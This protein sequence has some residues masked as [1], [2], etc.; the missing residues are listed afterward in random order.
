MP[1]RTD[2][3]KIMIIGSG[4]IIIGQAC[5]F[6][7]SGTQ[8]C[9][10]LRAEGY[11]VVLVNS[12]PATIMTDPEI[13]DRTYVEPL[14]LD[15]LSAVVERERPDAL[16][17]TMG[18]QTG[19]NLA[20]GLSERGVLDTFGVELIGANAQAIATA[21]DRDQFKSAMEEIGLEVPASGFASHLD[22][23]MAL[24]ERIGFPLMIRPSFILG[25]AGTGTAQDRA[26]LAKAAA[27]GL[28]ASPVHQIL[29][30]RSIAGWK[31]YELEV[32]R[33]RADNCVVVCSIENFDPMGVHT[34]D[35]ITVAP[36]QT[37]TDVEYQG[38][39][40]DAFACLRRVGVE[41]GGSNV[42]FAVD[43]QTGRRVI[44]EMNPRVSRSSALAS[45][46]T[47]FPI[48]KIAA[49]LAVGYHLDEIPNDITG[50]T[51]ASFE[52]TI[53]YVVVKIPRFQFEKFPG[54]DNKLGTRMQSV[55]EVMAIG[56]TFCESLQKALRSLEQGRFGLNAD[57]AE[58]TLDALSDDELLERVA[59]APPE[60]IFELEAALRRGAAVEEVVRRTGID[61]WFVRQLTRIVAERR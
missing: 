9:R 7:Y 44:I 5:E 51:P 6:D 45:K 20:F 57:P 58:E 24:G 54:A 53:D 34:G 52:P 26:E 56:R 23:A 55:G 46:A 3:K 61:P 8:A 41:T 49:R 4:P 43:P 33:D 31:E 17:P 42:Q 32:M 22:E 13:A 59:V 12:N 40:D 60:R 39:R 28:A 14:D 36:A 18:G 35:S 15:V 29:I 27:E 21:E 11:R 47:G 10:A 16:L 50:A 37:L 19:L 2:I 30:E 38:M 48:A 1:K 25:G